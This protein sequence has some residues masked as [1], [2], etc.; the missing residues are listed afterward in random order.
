[1][2]EFGNCLV[3]LRVKTSF[4]FFRS[5]KLYFTPTFVSSE[6]IM[7][8]EV[9]DDGWLDTLSSSDCDDV[10]SH[11]IDGSNSGD[12][13]KWY[14]YEETANVSI[15]INTDCSPY[16]K[17]IVSWTKDLDKAG[18]CTDTQI[19]SEIFCNLDLSCKE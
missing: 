13:D 14:L 17:K 10:L 18:F 6:E 12:L 2:F 5:F 1:M 8:F 3:H 15:N 19:A 9:P 16:T 7:F 11:C 4:T